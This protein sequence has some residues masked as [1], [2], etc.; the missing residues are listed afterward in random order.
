MNRISRFTSR[1]WSRGN[2]LRSMKLGIAGLAT[3]L[4]SGGLGLAGLQKRTHAITAPPDP[5]IFRKRKQL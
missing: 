2:D 5:D 4:L 1:P 3:T